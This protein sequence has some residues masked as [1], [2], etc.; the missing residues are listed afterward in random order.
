MSLD[1][2]YVQIVS[3]HLSVQKKFG[4]MQCFLKNRMPTLIA[5]APG[6]GWRLVA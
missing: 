1:D 5:E 2:G 3:L 4:N 6:L